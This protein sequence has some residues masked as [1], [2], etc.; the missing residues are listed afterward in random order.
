MDLNDIHVQKM[1][2]SE[3]QLRILVLLLLTQI[4]SLFYEISAN[5]LQLI[6]KCRLYSPRSGLPGIGEGTRSWNL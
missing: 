1:H 6:R 5:A 2:N 3:H 4:L